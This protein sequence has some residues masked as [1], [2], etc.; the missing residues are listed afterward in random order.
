VRDTKATIFRQRTIRA[1]QFYGMALQETRPGQE[2]EPMI[3][4][5]FKG[6][7]V[8][9]FAACVAPAVNAQYCD[10]N[11][12]VPPVCSPT[13][14]VPSGCSS[15]GSTGNECNSCYQ[16]QAMNCEPRQGG[17][18]RCR[19]LFNWT[20]IKVE[21]RE[22]C[23]KGQSDP[24]TQ[25]AATQS[26]PMMSFQPV[27]LQMTAYQP[28]MVQQMVAAPQFVQAAPQFVQS[29][30]QFVQAAPQMVQQVAFRPQAAAT[31]SSDDCNLANVCDKLAALTDR[32]KALEERVATSSSS[33]NSSD[34]EKRMTDAEKAIKLQTEILG[35][36]R[37]KLMQ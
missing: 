5:V 16:P 22:K 7:A 12:A 17:M 9:A 33:G 24:G 18:F 23:C 29:A 19:P 15:C 1:G 10:P 20:H 34:I 6:L 27:Q 14:A 8:L 4:F 36:I 13:C 28:M 2:D 11:C 21:S 37:D 3:H 35:E 31:Q 32:M 25:T 30:P 26:V